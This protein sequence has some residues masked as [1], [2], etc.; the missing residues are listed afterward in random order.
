MLIVYDAILNEYRCTS[1]EVV[2][3]VQKGGLERSTPV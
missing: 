1:L 2:F 3:F